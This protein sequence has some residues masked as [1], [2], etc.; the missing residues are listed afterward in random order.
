MVMKLTE[1]QRHEIDEALIKS[2]SVLC[3]VKRRVL[4]GKNLEA[5]KLLESA[6]QNME[7]FRGMVK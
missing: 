1:L 7:I 3:N 5:M 2:S 4:K 6:V